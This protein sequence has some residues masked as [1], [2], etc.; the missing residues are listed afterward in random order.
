MGFR[1]KK[2][3]FNLS[4]SSGTNLVAIGAEYNAAILNVVVHYILKKN[5]Q[6][7]EFNPSGIL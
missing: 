4:F 6:I 2:S 1:I 5:N 7:I 3:Y